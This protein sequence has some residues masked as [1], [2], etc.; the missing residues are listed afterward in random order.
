MRRLWTL[1]LICILLTTCLT[2]VPRAGADQA[3]LRG[4]WVDGFHD[5]YKTAEQTTEMV[6]KVADANLNAIFV[7]VRK[8]GDAYYNSSIVPKATDIA[9]DYDPL[10]DVIQKAHAKGIEVHAWIN[11]LCVWYKGYERIE[12][13]VFF[14]HPEW[15]TKT[16][17]TNSIYAREDRVYLDPALPEVRQHLADVVREIVSKYDVDGIC[18]DGFRYA[19]GRLGYSDTAVQAFNTEYKR[20]GKPAF[21]DPDWCT[22]RRQQIT[23]LTKAVSDAVKAVKPRMKITASVCNSKE[24]SLSRR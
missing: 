24:L 6:N 18:V 15:L 17:Y 23:L 11:P 5:G 9:K 10:A 16:D 20:E 7:Q 3:E 13:N 8:R 1:G 12:G 2:V 4:I 22:W 14:Q 21:D 19:N